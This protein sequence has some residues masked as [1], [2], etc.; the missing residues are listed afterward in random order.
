MFPESLYFGEIQNSNIIWATFFS[1]YIYFKIIPLC[2]YRLLPATVKV[3]QT[4]LG[5]ILLEPFHSS[6]A[7]LMMSLASQKSRPFNVLFRSREQVKISCSQDSREDIP[8][9]WHFSLLWNP[10]QNQLVCWSIVVKEKPTLGSPFFCTFRSDHI[11]KATKDV[12]IHLFIHSS[13]S[14][15]SYQAFPENYTSELWKLFEVTT[16][17]ILHLT[18]RLHLSP[19]FL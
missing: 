16:Y 7:F 2:Q 15:K 1:R 18:Q 3:I 19:R 4:F 9:V 5:T 12:I 14:H 8:V 17:Y 11:P 6:I 10:Y 13:N